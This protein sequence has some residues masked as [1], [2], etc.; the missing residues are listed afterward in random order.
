MHRH[1]PVWLTRLASLLATLASLAFVGSAQA[2]GPTGEFAVFE[3]CPTST[4]GVNLCLYSRITSG[5]VT[6]GKET[7][8]LENAITLQ[9]GIQ[10]NEE[11]FVTSFVGATNGETFSKTPQNVPGGLFGMVKCNEITGTG[12]AEAFE[13]GYCQAIFEN[14]ITEVKAVTELAVPANEI[15]INLTNLESREGTGLSVPVKVHLENP[16]LGS[17][18]YIGSDS[19]PIV[20]NLTTGTTAPSPPNKPIEGK[21]GNV[22]A[23]DEFELI[24]DTNNTLVD[25]DFA[26]PGASGCGGVFASLIDPIINEKLG[27]PSPAGYNTAI[28][29]DTILEATA[30]GVIAS[31]EQPT[32]GVGQSNTPEATPSQGSSASGVGASGTSAG[33]ASASPPGPGRGAVSSASDRLRPRHRCGRHPAQRSSSDRAHTAAKTK[34]RGSSR[35]RCAA[36]RA[37]RR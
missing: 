31:E 5:E 20:L 12:L 19:R 36:P 14:S 1:N 13:R 25:N 3:Q 35:E 21:V 2:A 4:P 11:T 15:Q 8:P 33:G 16:L 24:E 30:I 9:G 27:L 10:L 32:S 22:S 18:C 6:I 34:R 37:K 26:A 23:K 28:E 7:V 29:N 17:E